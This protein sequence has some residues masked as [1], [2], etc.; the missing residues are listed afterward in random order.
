M[1]VLWLGPVKLQSNRQTAY[2]FDPDRFYGY[3][4]Q[5]LKAML[6]SEK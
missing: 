4:Q 2:P 1:I 3:G 5:K 6:T